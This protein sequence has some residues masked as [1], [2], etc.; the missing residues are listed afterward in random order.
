MG[1]KALLLAIP[2]FLIFLYLNVFLH[3]L[4]HVIAA[5]L[6]GIG[7]LKVVIGT[8][9]EIART[10]VLGFPWVITSNPIGGYTFPAGID[11][12]FLRPRLLFVTAGGP[13]FQGFWILLGI[14]LHQVFPSAFI[15]YRGVDLLGIFI[16]SNVTAL[17]FSL[18]PMRASYQGM[19]V[20]SDMLRVFGLLFGSNEA[21]EP[22][23]ATGLLH[24][25]SRY[26]DN[27]E[28][29]QAAGLLKQCIEQYPD[30]IIAKINLSVTLIRAMRLQ[31]AKELLITLN[32]EKRDD[33]YD[34]FIY[35]NLAWVF[36]LENNNETLGEADR[37]SKMAF[38]LNPDLPPIKGTRACVL[39]S[40]GTVDEGINLLLEN[41]HMM[42]PIDSKG[43]H[44]I[45]FCFLAYAY[46][47]KGEKDKVRQYLKP[48][49]DYQ[50][51]DLDEKYLYDVLKSKAEDFKGI[52]QDVDQLD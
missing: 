11:G 19:K 35:N 51:W 29:E 12:K 30:Q 38:E 43:N 48:I 50:N 28:Y 36:L 14:G 27:K 34:F 33:Q 3:E 37:F 26:F 40:Q 47:L 49:E 20:P 22:F 15:V 6:A 24:E 42:E 31:D 32:E 1:T 25:A 17:F 13:L 21:V 39:I 18:V 5:R 4:G 45:W 7:I 44:P 23:Q 10:T 16:F 52:F 9:R 8:G 46:Y 41:V 2:T